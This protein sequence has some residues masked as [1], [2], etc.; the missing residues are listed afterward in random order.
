LVHPINKLGGVNVN[1]REIDQH[2]S[3]MEFKRSVVDYIKTEIDENNQVPSEK[4]LIDYFGNLTEKGE[5]YIV[6]VLETYEKA[7]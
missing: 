5:D 1:Q 3:E 6:S 4:E 2:E 7:E